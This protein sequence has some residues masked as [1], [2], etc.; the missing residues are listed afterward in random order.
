M[1]KMFLMIIHKELYNVKLERSSIIF[2]VSVKRKGLTV[3]INRFLVVHCR[4]EVGKCLS[5]TQLL[6]NDQKIEKLF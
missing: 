1:R 2:F 3:L 5:E 4:S 6:L